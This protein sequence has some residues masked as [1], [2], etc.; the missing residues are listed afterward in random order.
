[1][2]YERT[3]T[4]FVMDMVF[5]KSS[6]HI[7]EALEEQGMSTMVDFM[8]FTPEDFSEMETAIYDSKT[9]TYQTTKLNKICQRKL[10]AIQDWY[11][12]QPSQDSETW[13]SLTQSSLNQFIV[14]KGSSVKPTSAPPVTPMS[15]V[16]Y[17]SSATSSSLLQ[18]FQKSIK[19]SVSDYSK[20]KE[21]K[22][23]SSWQRNLLATASTHDLLDVFTPDFIPSSSV[24]E[25]LF[26][27]KNQF[28]YSV[29]TATLLTAKSKRHI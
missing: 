14:S 22:Y 16:T 19:R 23:F 2:T 13:Y 15:G 6:S 8:L 1:M 29:F 3:E 24:E 26:M 4:D 7:K 27:A 18:D 11:R 12:A 10:A 9:S 17:V 25:E 28:A 20:L 5:G 21:D